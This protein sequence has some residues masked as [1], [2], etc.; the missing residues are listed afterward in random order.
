MP[1]ELAGDGD[2]GDAPEQCLEQNAAAAGIEICEK[3]H[4]TLSFLVNTI[5][6]IAF[7][8]PRESP[9]KRA[10]H[11]FVLASLVAAPVLIVTDAQ[12]FIGRGASSGEVVAVA[13]IVVVAVPAALA[14]FVF[15][16][17]ALST[18]VGW[19]LQLLLVGA[20]TALIISEALYPLGLRLEAQA[21]LVL[22]AGIAAAIA[23]ARFEGVRSTV[24]ALIALPIVIVAYVFLLTP[25]SGLVFAGEPEV[26]EPALE[27][28]EAPVV[29]VVFDELPG[30]ALMN[31]KGKLD[32]ERFPNFAA[33]GEDATWYPNASTSRSDTELAVPTAMTGIDA[34]LDSLGTASDHPESLFTLLG[35]SHEMHVSEPWTNVCP[36][37]LCDGSTQSTDEGGLG[38]LLA[39]IPPILGYV[40]VPD[41]QRVGIPSPRESGAVSRPHQFQT[42]TEEVAPADGPV[43]HFLHVLLPHKAWR[44][45]PS[46]GRYSDTVGADAELGGLAKWDE[47]EWPVLQAEQRFLLQL[48]FTDR[49]LG[50]LLDKLEAE[51]LYDES[52]IVVTADHGVAFRAGEERRDATEPNAGDILSVPLFVKLPGQRRGQIDDAPAQTVD[53][54]P[55]I[56]D[57]IGAELPWEVDGESLLAGPLPERAVEVENLRGGG[58]EL[59]EAEFEDARAEALAR[60]VEALGD[61]K[62]SLYAIGPSPELHDEEVAALVGDDADGEASIIDGK[63]IRDFDPDSDVVPARI[64]GEVSGVEPGEPLAIA[65]DGRVAATTYA[66]EGDYATE[67]AAMVPP[68]LLAPGDNGLEIYAIEGEPDGPE[69]RPLRL[70]F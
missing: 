69:L 52:M 62:D 59:T 57:A 68:A 30:H 47:D 64:A 7:V 35:S 19:I 2:R 15:L 11:V 60:R 17:S 8:Q 1:P 36:D 28:V 63:T 70:S 22:A 23:Y 65:L 42:F 37:E 12:F 49:L 13:L 5:F 16:V 3:S 41:A 43:L 24:S 55:T 44:Y 53:V 14:L 58:V 31:A 10:L 61:G 9:G 6:T 20:L 54:V 46:G 32:A 33:L 45:L 51:G 29:M 50:G 18:Q 34:P 26:E 38:E 39:T 66:Y 4:A 67:F 40:S 48:R 25:V 27:G 21:P 56:A